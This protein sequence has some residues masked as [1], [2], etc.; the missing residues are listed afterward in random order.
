[1][2]FFVA[3]CQFVHINF[4]PIFS[5]FNIHSRLIVLIETD[6]FLTLFLVYFFKF[7]YATCV[8]WS[9]CFMTRLLKTYYNVTYMVRTYELCDLCDLDIFVLN[10]VLPG[11]RKCNGIMCVVQTHT[12][13]QT[14]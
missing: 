9:Y 11:I 2:S 1:M 12:G 7:F 13:H 3:S 10:H 6:C 8:V 14:Y 4:H 5:T